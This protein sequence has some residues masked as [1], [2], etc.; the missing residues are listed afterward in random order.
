MSKRYAAFTIAANTYPMA[1]WKGPKYQTCPRWQ[2][3]K[4]KRDGHFFFLF[5]DNPDFQS[6]DR[7]TLRCRQEGKNY[8]NRDPRLSEF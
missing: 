8:E 6:D 1:T 4:I 5:L 2:D 3:E 7:E